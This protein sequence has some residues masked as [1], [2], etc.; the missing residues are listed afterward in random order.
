MKLRKCPECRTYTLKDSC[1]KCSAQTR[2]MAP[3][4]YS[5]QD[6]Y[7]RYRRLMKAWKPDDAKPDDV[8]CSGE[9]NA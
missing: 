7:G 2:N 9:T 6:P 1:I 3:A 5:P 4:R 8:P